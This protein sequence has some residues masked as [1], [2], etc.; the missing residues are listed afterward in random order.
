MK[1]SAVQRYKRSVTFLPV[2]DPA[3]FHRAAAYVHKT[4][5]AVNG[6]TAL[7]FTVPYGTWSMAIYNNAHQ[8]DFWFYPKMREKDAV[9]RD[10]YIAAA[11]Q[12]LI[13]RVTA[14]FEEWEAE[15]APRPLTPT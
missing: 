15:G 14:L 3:N 11:S 6:L 13:E 2:D 7:T 8:V 1:V 12:E 10:R 4:L 9:I 5:Y